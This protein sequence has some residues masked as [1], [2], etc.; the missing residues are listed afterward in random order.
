MNPDPVSTHPKVGRYVSAHGHIHVRPRAASMSAYG[1]IRMSLD[2]EGRWSPIWWAVVV[3]E[4]TVSAVGE[5]TVSPSGSPR[6]TCG[7]R[8]AG[9]PVWGWLWELPSVTE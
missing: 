5:G 2:R 6:W 9:L 4:D 8:G 3:A 7:L 1:Q